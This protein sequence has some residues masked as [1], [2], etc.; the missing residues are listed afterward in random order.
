MTDAQK[1]I[2][3][4]DDNEDTREM[5]TLLLDISGYKVITAGKI[6][7]A[8]TLDAEYS[9]DLYMIDNLLEDGTGVDLCLQLQ[10]LRPLT[11]V[12]FYSGAGYDSDIKRAIDAGAGGYLVKPATLKQIESSI[13]RLL[14]KKPKKVLTA[15]PPAPAPACHQL[16]K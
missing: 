11:P 10:R 16:I 3:F 5:M 14:N 2:L 4:V 13:E 15:R 7:D 8:L 12:L 6:A 9:F 1:W